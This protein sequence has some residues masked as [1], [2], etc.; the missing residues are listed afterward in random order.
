MYLWQM[1]PYF[2]SS[3]RQEAMITK[4][5]HEPQKR[6]GVEL[7]FGTGEMCTYGHRNKLDKLI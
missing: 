7:S 3:T 4:D 1:D 6:F 2:D 5:A